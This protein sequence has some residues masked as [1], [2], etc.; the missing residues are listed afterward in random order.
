[1]KNEIAKKDETPIATINDMP[2]IQPLEQGDTLRIPRLML[3]QEKHKGIREG[4]AQMG[5][6]VNTLTK[7]SYGKS[8]EIVPVLQRPLTRIKWAA[9]TSGGGLECISRNKTK[10]RGTPGDNYQS[11]TDCQFYSDNSPDTGCTQNYEIVALVISGT[12]P[13][14]WEPILLTAEYTRPSDAGIRNILENVRYNANRGIRMFH[15]P[16]VIS[17]ADAKNKFGDFYKTAC[18][19]GTFGGK[20]NNG[21]LPLDVITYL[22]EQMKF[23]STAKIDEGAEGQTEST[24]EIPIDPK[25]GAPKGW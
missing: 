11:C 9:R 3:I 12:E 14:F 22:E 7:E 15:K 21:L 19:P 4:W 1:M 16:Y 23:F 20:L 24:E 8:I 10:P 5:T 6:L 18:A 2:E 17:V 25:T 13:R